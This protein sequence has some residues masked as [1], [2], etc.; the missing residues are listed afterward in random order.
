MLVIFVEAIIYLLLYNLHDCC[1]KAFQKDDIPTKVIRMN[2]DIFTGLIAKDFNNRVDK[3]VFPDDLMH[4][5][6][7]PIHKKKDKSDQLQVSK[8]TSKYFKSI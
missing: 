2:K 5:D 1:F 7:T 6:V 3:G 8:C 4:A